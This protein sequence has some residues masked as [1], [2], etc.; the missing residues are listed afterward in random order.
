MRGKV[1]GN[2]AGLD[3]DYMNGVAAAYLALRILYGVVSCPRPFLSG[4]TDAPSPSSDHIRENQYS[5]TEP[6]SN[7]SMV[8][9]QL[10]VG[11]PGS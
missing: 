10:C 6:A 3:A 11:L 1:A 4:G 7:S 9:V 5:G 2:F 8:D